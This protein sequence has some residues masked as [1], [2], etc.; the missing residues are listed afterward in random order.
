[1][2]TTLGLTFFAQV[3]EK[4]SASPTPSPAS[5]GLTTTLDIAAVISAVFWPVVVLI[6]LLAYRKEIP[7]FVEGIS[8]RITKLGFGGFSIELAKATAFAPD[9]SAGALDLRQRAT[10]VQ[11]TDSTAATFTTQLLGG[12]SADYAEANLGTGTEWLTSRLF[13]MAI[14][15]ARMKGVRCF[16]FVETACVVR[17]RFIGW[18]EPEKI[19]WALARQYPWLEKAYADAYHETMTSST[20]FIVTNQGGIGQKL[21]PLDPG[22]TLDLL[23]KFL[24]RIQKAYKP[25]DSPPNLAE[26]IPAGSCHEHL[27]ACLVDQ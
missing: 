13:I 5:P 17:R 8:S 18:A 3:A 4:A 12:G 23:K 25:P 11:V 20:T 26:W 6:I 7:G 15:F 19:R 10:A 2:I 22:S 16:V 21:F 1:M 24:E 27:R 14:L 9:W